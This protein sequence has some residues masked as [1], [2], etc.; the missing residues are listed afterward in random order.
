M[1]EKVEKHDAR[2]NGFDG[3]IAR[4]VKSLVE[5]HVNDH[6]KTFEKSFN[7]RIQKIVSSQEESDT[8][9]ARTNANVDSLR[10]KMVEH[11]EQLRQVDKLQLDSKPASKYQEEKEGVDRRLLE[12]EKAMKSASEYGKQIQQV[13]GKL[14]ALEASMQRIFSNPGST[15]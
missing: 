3:H 7:E 9:I 10:T 2:L 6:I 11:T 1:E 8:S 14:L 12:L 5:Q 13:W 4:L 15:K